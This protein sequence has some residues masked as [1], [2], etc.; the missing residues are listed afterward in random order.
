MRESIRDVDDAAVGLRREVDS[1]TRWVEDEVE[2]FVR[3]GFFETKN[4]LAYP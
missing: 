2:D 3:F 1:W 4:L